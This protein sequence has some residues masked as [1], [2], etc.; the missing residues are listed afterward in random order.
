M[1]LNHENQVNN[2]GCVCVFS[3]SLSVC[4]GL[5]VDNNAKDACQDRSELV[6]HMAL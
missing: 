6:T 2:D 5:Q 3:F 4:Q 1:V